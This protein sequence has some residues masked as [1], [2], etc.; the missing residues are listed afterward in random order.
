MPR[1]K[2]EELAELLKDAMV[3]SEIALRA[4]VPL[5]KRI[6]IAVYKLAT[7]AEYRRVA[8]AFGV[9]ITTVHRCV[10]KFCRTMCAR[11]ANVIF[12]SR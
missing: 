3:P 6:C 2:V 5:L 9:S 1:A 10:Q 4:P 7:C 8:K 11:K 12:W